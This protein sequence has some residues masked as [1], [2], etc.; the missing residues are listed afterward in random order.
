MKYYV[1]CEF[2]GHNGPLLSLALVC[3]DGSSIH[4]ETTARAKDPWVVANVVPLMSEND[5]TTHPLVEPYQVGAHIRAFVGSDPT[6]TVIADSPV[7]IG[8]FCQALMTDERGQYAPNTW[9]RWVFRVHDVDCYP[10]DLPGAVQHNAW[11]DAMALRHKLE[12]Q[13]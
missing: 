8:R 5:A 6:P 9:D 4:I 10:T 1:D 2:D 12:S 7:D 13:P 3:D 11:W